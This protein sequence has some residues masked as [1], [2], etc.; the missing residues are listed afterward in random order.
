MA[1]WTVAGKV[2]LI[3]GASSGIG[4]ETASGLANLGAKVVMVCRNQGAGE[5]ARDTVIL[6]SGNSEVDLLIADLARQ[7]DIHKLATTIRQIYPQLD[8]LINNAAVASPRRTL[9]AD[10]IETTFAVNY[11]AP[12][13]LTN[14]LVASVIQSRSARIINVV[15][16]QHQPVDFNDLG[17]EKK[18]NGMRAY[19][20]SKFA[21]IV[22]SY[23][24]AQRLAGSG[25]S[26]NC[27]HPGL[28]ATGLS[29]DFPLPFRLMTRF[30][31]SRPVEGA[32]VP[33][34][35]AT[36][37]E[38]TE[39]SGKYFK[40]C[41][42]ARSHPATYNRELAARLWEVSQHLTRHSSQK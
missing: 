24:L 12:F 33:I 21:L 40:G 42:Q 30:F 11:L 22:F 6:K 25:I 9:T 10:G 39:V 35:L 23:E 28:V 27:L 26:V 18:W 13:L 2:C 31:F 3:T 14:L 1:R 29:R 34:Y 4:L 15:S 7:A 19:A 41:H 20:R 36:S 32:R 38:L 17:N 16:D 37:P 8:V 5:A